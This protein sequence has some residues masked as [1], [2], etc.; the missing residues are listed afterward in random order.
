MDEKSQSVPQENDKT[1]ANENEP[2]EKLGFFRDFFQKFVE[3][4]KLLDF[5]EPSTKN[6]RKHKEPFTWRIL[7]F[8]NFL[9]FTIS[10]MAGSYLVGI[11]FKMAP[12]MSVVEGYDRGGMFLTVS[13][14][15]YTT[16]MIALLGFC[17]SNSTL[18]NRRHGSGHMMLYMHMLWVFGMIL[19]LITTIAM[20]HGAY[21]QLDDNFQGGFYMSM[22]KYETDKA[23][24]LKIDDIQK[25]FKCC[26]NMGPDE[27]FKIS[28]DDMIPDDKKGVPKSCCDTSRFPLDECVSFEDITE[29][30]GLTIFYESCLENIKSRYRQVLN[31]CFASMSFSLS[32][33]LICFVLGILNIRWVKNYRK[34]I[35]RERLRHLAKVL[36]YT[37][38]GQKFLNKLLSKEESELESDVLDKI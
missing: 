26:G 4:E 21:L 9:I 18:H 7:S 28:W 24:A 15:N 35:L 16:G 6:P 12:Y 1:L 8:F 22:L 17:M 3:R 25:D 20:C 29:K 10:F 11:H 14:V 27:W 5:T 38:I 37:E 36:D 2:T 23:V 30:D 31:V 33:M 32:V 13:A 34:I 19:I